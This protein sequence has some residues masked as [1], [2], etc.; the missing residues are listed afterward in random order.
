MKSLTPQTDAWRA[1]WRVMRML[2]DEREAVERERCARAD[3]RARVAAISPT[4]AHQVWREE[5]AQ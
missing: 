1:Q 3:D 4:L 2:A 5:P